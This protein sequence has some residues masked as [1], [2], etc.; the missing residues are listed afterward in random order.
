V[1]SPRSRPVLVGVLGGQPLLLDHA[2]GW[3]RLLD[4]PLRVVHVWAFPANTPEAVV[5]VDLEA[6]FRTAAEGVLDEARHHL[7][8]CADLTI[9]YEMPVGTAAGVLGAESQD[10]ALVVLGTDL[11]GWV[12]RALGGAVARHVALHVEPPVVVVPPEAPW[13]PPEHIVL[14][15]DPRGDAAGPRAFAL[16]VASRTGGSVEAVHVIDPHTR[17]HERAR[18]HDALE[19]LHHEAV[20][21][22]PEVPVS[23]RL[24]AG[25]AAEETTLLSRT[26]ELVVLGRPR[27]RH[28][29]LLDDRSVT[30]GVLRRTRCAAA[31]VPAVYDPRRP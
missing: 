28:L 22:R 14:A 23:T 18:L 31:V 24:V 26:A 19:V 27:E 12:G 30:A 17:A 15:L 25:Q 6:T 10:A 2:V 29:A 21:G 11:S 5:G 7:E 3:S 13:R 20:S 1:S 16:L 9:S 8:G 4:A